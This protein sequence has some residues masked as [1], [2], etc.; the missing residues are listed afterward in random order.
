MSADIQKQLQ[1][2]SDDYQKLQ[3]DLQ[4]NV[5]SRQKLEAQQQENLGVQREFNT[6]PDTSD[7]SGTGQIYKLVGPVL[8]KQD[9]NEA[10]LAVTGRLDYI[11]NEI[12][13][14]EEKIEGIQEESEKRKMEIYQIQSQA[15]AAGAEDQAQAA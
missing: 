4:T 9:K 6:L 13:R 14:I 8:L 7:P 10:M 2:L 15:Q 12:K 3:G 1:T 5:Q 11:A